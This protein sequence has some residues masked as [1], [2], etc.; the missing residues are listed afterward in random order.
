L[1]AHH[2][3]Y[4]SFSKLLRMTFDDA[5]R[6]IP[7]Q[8][9]DLLHIDGLHSYDA[10][11]RDYDTWRPKLS[12]RGVV[13][14]HDTTVTDEGFG[15]RQLWA[16]L[17]RDFPHFNF[18]HGHGLGVLAV[19]REQS[20]GVKE[21]LHTANGRPDATRQLFSALGHRLQCQVEKA[22]APQPRSLARR[23]VDRLKAGRTANSGN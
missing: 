18:E 4:E 12:G 5:L 1:A 3:Q 23:F 19:G 7:D 10:V 9:V 14:F 8:S 21:F 17:S 2:R 11:K 16:E 15:V 22:A 20:E 13:L 6:E